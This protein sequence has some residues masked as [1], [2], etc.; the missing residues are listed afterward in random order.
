MLI[1]EVA[2]IQI[3]QLQVSELAPLQMLVGQ[4]CRYRRILK[5]K[6]VMDTW[7]TVFHLPYVSGV[8]GEIGSVL[9]HRPYPPVP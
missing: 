5:G 6:S 2:E 7:D 3:V 8:G 9:L 4:M 1:G